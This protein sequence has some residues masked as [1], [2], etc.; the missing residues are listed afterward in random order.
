MRNRVTGHDLFRDALDE[1]NNDLYL[2]GF[3]QAG[4]GGGRYVFTEDRRARFDELLGIRSTALPWNGSCT[5]FS[6]NAGD[7]GSRSNL[8]INGPRL[9]NA[10][11]QLGRATTHLQSQNGRAAPSQALV[12]IIRGTSEAARFG[13]IFDNI[14]TNIRDHRTGGAQMGVEN[15]DLQ[16]LIGYVFYMEPAD[17]SR[18]R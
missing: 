10:L 4:Q 2:A 16:Q 11:Q 13:R 1:I 14:R 9:D 8:Q 5:N 15:V 12:M 6:G 3:Y 17:G 7:Q 18:P